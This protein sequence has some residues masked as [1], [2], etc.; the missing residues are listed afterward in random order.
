MKIVDS[1][2]RDLV[3]LPVDTT[4]DVVADTLSDVGLACESVDRVGATVAGVITAR[5]V[6]TERHPDAAKVHRVFLDIGDGTEHHVW[7]GAFN[8]QPGD[9]IPWATPGTTMPDGR[10]I[11]TKPIVGIPSEGMCCSA[12]ELGLGDDHS[13]ILIL[14]P[15]TPLGVPYGQALGLAEETVYDL[16]VLRNRPDAY[17]HVGVARDL[18]ARFGVPFTAPAGT[19]VANGPTRS[20]TV[21]IVDGDRC[22]R[23]TSVVLSGV[24]VTES[25]DWMKSRLSAAGMRPINNVVD[26]SNYVMLETNQ[27]NHAYDFDTLGGG[28]FR[29]RVARDGESMITLDGVERTLTTDDLLICDATDRPIGIAGI[30]GGQN[31]EISDSTTVVALETAYFEPLGIMKSVQLLALR[32]EASARNERGIDPLGVESSIARFV[33]LLRLTCP[34]LVVHDGFVDARAPSMPVAP[35]I[36]VRPAR[37]SALLGR[38]FTADEISMLITPLGFPCT[39][40][41]SNLAVSVPSWRP[42]CTLEIDIV[43][44]VARLFGYDRLGKTVPKSTVPGGLSPIQQRRRR[45]RDVLLGL[46]ISEAMPH[47]FLAEGDLERAGLSGDAVRLVNPLVVGDDVLRTSLRPGLV[48]A[49]SF[50]ES[51]RR[52]GVA[53]FEIGHVYPPS[54]QELPAEYEALCVVMAGAE[55]P[56]AVAV[57]RELA[58]A[59]GWGARLDQSNVPGGLHPTRSATLSAGRDVVGAVGEIHPDVLDAFDVNERVAILELNLSVLLAAEPKVAQWKATSRFPSS[60]I[61]LAFNVPSSVTAE[62]VDKALRQSAGSLLVS[63]ELFDVYRAA[64]SDESRS[65]AFRLR[66]QASDRTLTDADI[67][68]VRDKCVAAVSKLGASL[69]S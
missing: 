6:K 41:G 23:F 42:D 43:E 46:G 39:A 45:V 49:L 62:K 40:E 14:D 28:G 44:E 27:P 65:L 48:K 21:E 47:P 59:M 7:C 68:G 29:I 69:R 26:V 51:H 9:V 25:P 53:L 4:V 61:D 30:M 2:L 8:M 12:R 54:D 37:V 50:N 34:D 57:W 38:P 52:A 11:E 55:A 1:W 18:A 17:G 31:A 24:R 58:S 33:E 16:D 67:A 13:G 22:P 64:A 15:E 19:L 20:A 63:L 60:D 35:T 32:S 36:I 66:L 5:V 56:R 3:A 10:L